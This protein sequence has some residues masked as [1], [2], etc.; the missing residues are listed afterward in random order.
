MREIAL[1]ALWGIPGIRQRIVALPTE[2]VLT[3]EAAREREFR[4]GRAI[5]AQLLLEHGSATGRVGVGLDRSPQWPP[6][7]IGTISHSP[8]LLGVAI[9]RR[10]AV[11][12]RVADAPGQCGIGID[13]EP[14]IEGAAVEDIRRFCLCEEERGVRRPLSSR[15]DAMTVTAIFS[16]KEALFKC[17]Y[18]I[19]GSF[20]DFCDVVIELNL[21]AAEI[22]GQLKRAL[23][24]ELPVG[25][26]VL[27]RCRFIEQHV[28]TA[29]AWPSSALFEN[30]TYL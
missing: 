25:T 11:E 1:P 15:E 24:P 27:G 5:A 23:S 10:D 18:P 3:G 13:I 22:R 2:P 21:Q 16:A 28:V 12:M 6:G 30:I 14:I 7:F 20:F 4:L 17:L 8:A 29:F 19:V 9:A 26:R